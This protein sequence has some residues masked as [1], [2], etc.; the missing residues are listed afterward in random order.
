MKERKLLSNGEK[1]P[2]TGS[3]PKKKSHRPRCLFTSLARKRC[4]IMA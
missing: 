2:Y 1:K 3:N 4:V